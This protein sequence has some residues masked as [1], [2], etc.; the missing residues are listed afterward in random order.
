MIRDR[1]FEA[2]EQAL[3]DE[4]LEGDV[5]TRDETQTNKARGQLVLWCRDQI[6]TINIRVRNPCMNCPNYAADYN[7]CGRGVPGAAAVDCPHEE[8]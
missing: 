1:I 7:W 3:V 4:T 6:V 2:I 8:A 5:V